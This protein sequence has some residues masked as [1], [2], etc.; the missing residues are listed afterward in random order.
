[1][2]EDEFWQFIEVLGGSA[3]EDAVGRLADAL[4]AAGKRKAIGFA[5]RLAATLYEL[6]RIELFRQPVRW[7][8]APGEDILPLSD[9]SFL[10]L[11]A[12]IVARGKDTVDA[13]LADPAVLQTALWDDGEALLY[14][15]D[16]AVD[17]EIETRL[18]YETGSNRA[19]WPPMP[20]DESDHVPPLV[21]VLLEDL[22]VLLEGFLF[23]DAEMTI[24]APPMYA[25]PMWFPH[26]VLD[27]ASTAA[28]ALVREGG[29]VPPELDVVQL[30]V[31]IGLG[32]AWQLSP[33]IEWQVQDD[34]G[35]GQVLRACTQM[36][37]ADVRAWTPQQQ[38]A[39]LLAVVATSLLAAL[40]EQHD[41]RAGLERAATDGAHV[42]PT[43]G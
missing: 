9:D 3:D 16:E 25:W 5:E 19:H 2:P 31:V 36:R 20:D 11:R 1:M 21:A 13:V 38:E 6:D 39:G 40:P 18:S 17:D 26:D 23:L 37:Q 22:L 35:L 34:T 33:A 27:A 8:D 15:A 30:Q 43:L 14:A 12:G 4:R 28:D 10:Y 32:D 42:L 29:G 7:A 24:P 41:S